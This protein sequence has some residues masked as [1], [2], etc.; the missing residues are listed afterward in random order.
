MYELRCRSFKL[1]VGV[2]LWAYMEQIFYNNL[3]L[4]SFH[5]KKNNDVSD[6]FV[7]LEISTIEK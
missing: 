7:G 5:Q 2:R 1:G 3:Y 4:V 6:R